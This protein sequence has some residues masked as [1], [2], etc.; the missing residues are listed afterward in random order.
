MMEFTNVIMFECR[1]KLFECSNVRSCR[2]AR[3]VRMLECQLK[4]FESSN[5][6]IQEQCCLCPVVCHYVSA[7]ASQGWL[8]LYFVGCKWVPGKITHRANLGGYPLHGFWEGIRSPDVEWTSVPRML[9][10]DPFQ[11]FRHIFGADLSPTSME[12]IPTQNPY[13]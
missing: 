8:F 9:S 10:V 12:R 13:L 6:R 7:S 5:V 11:M 1:L 2:I 3:N 4:L